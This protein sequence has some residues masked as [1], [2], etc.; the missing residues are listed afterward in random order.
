MDNATEWMAGINPPTEA[1]RLR[2]DVA[3]LERKL[4]A[5]NQEI[6][7]LRDELERAR[8]YQPTRDDRDRY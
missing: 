6:G 5:A 3:H 2:A 1:E 8:F 4:Q 7:R